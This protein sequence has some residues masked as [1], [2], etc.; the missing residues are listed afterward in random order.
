MTGQSWTYL[1]LGL[2]WAVAETAGLVQK[3]RPGRP[4]TL[5]AN[6]WWLVQGAGLWHHLARLGLLCGLV[7]LSVHLLTGGW[8]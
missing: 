4:R 6:I 2:A 1:A 8:V 5:S 3:D 7:W